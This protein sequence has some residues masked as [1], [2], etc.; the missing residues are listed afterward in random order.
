LTPSRQNPTPASITL[1]ALRDAAPADDVTLDWL[2]GKLPKQS[3]G[4]IMLLLAILAIAPGIS[5]VAGVLLL[6]PSFQMTV[7]RAGP[8]FPRWL[9]A[10]P[11]PSRRLGGAVARAIS[12]L[13]FLEKAIHPR[14]PTPREATKRAVGIA[15]LALSARLVLTP[16]P[17]S[18]VAPAVVIALISLAYL[19]EDG[20]LLVLS[21][22]AGLVLLGVDVSILWG[23]VRSAEGI[24]QVW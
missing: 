16:I 11:L 1:R 2:M 14:W 17:L 6:I 13:E 24:G 12:V 23:V 20:L 3:F 15:V 7:G 9:S 19:E 5:T 22:L 4:L 21:L 18:N 8:S 10:R